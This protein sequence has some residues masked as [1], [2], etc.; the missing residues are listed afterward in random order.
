MYGNAL[1]D[2]QCRAFSLTVEVEESISEGKESCLVTSE[3]SKPDYVCWKLMYQKDKY[4][5]EKTR[6]L[7]VVVETKHL[8][9]LTLKCIAQVIGY[10][11]RSA[12]NHCEPGVAL[13]LNEYERSVS[14]QVLFFH[15]MDR[16]N[17]E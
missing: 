15:I 9:N 6:T 13:L 7:A 14:I 11:S 2:M 1:I 17:L 3:K 16:I 5:F 4:N 12:K 10:Y 8:Q